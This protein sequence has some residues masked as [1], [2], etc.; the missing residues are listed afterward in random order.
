VTCLFEH[1]TLGRCQ[2]AQVQENLCHYHHRAKYEEGFRH[3]DYYHRK[4]V[5]GQLQPTDSYI[6]QQELTA[7]F[8]GRPRKDG[9]RMD[10]WVVE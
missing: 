7:L 1:P 8:K 4:V 2:Q 6:T 3:D 5:L 9:R 10:A